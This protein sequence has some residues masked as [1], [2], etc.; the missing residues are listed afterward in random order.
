MFGCLRSAR[1]IRF[2]GYSVAI[3]IQS[4]AVT[5]LAGINWRHAGCTGICT[6]PVVDT[7]F[8]VRG[9][10]DEVEARWLGLV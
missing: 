4:F 6:M 3:S 9:G 7:A 5:G 2:A 8:A 1:V 10:W